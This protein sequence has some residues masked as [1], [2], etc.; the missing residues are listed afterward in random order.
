MAGL[1]QLLKSLVL[2]C[3]PKQ[4][5]ICGLIF[6]GQRSL[7]GLRDAFVNPRLWSQHSS[8]LEE[9]LAEQ[10]SQTSGGTGREGEQSTPVLNETFLAAYEDVKK[11][12]DAMLF[13]NLPPRVLGSISSTLSDIK[14]VYSVLLLGTAPL[15][16]YYSS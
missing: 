13:R 12:N 16:V 15:T 1:E 6:S 7:L 5:I 14:V 8:L 2:V 9:I 10:I 4:R 11:R 3:S